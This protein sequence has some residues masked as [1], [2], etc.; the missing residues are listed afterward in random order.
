[1]YINGQKPFLFRPI[2]DNDPSVRT[3]TDATQ[4]T[5]FSF[6]TP[7]V[8]NDSIPNVQNNGVLDNIQTLNVQKAGVQDKQSQASNQEIPS[9]D[10][11]PQ[12]TASNDIYL[13]R[14]WECKYN[15]NGG[16]SLNSPNEGNTII[17]DKDGIEQGGEINGKS[18]KTTSKPDGTYS[19]EYNDGS[20]LNY[21]K[22]GHETGGIDAAGDRFTSVAKG[23]SVTR[24]YSGGLTVE[25]DFNNKGSITKETTVNGNEI[26]CT[27]YEYNDRGKVSQESVSKNNKRPQVTSY[28]YDSENRVT[29]RTKTWG[30]T[31]PETIE[32]KYLPNG[33]EIQ[34]T[35][36]GNSTITREYNTSGYLIK[37][38]SQ[39]GKNPPTI[40]TKKYDENNKVSQEIT[41]Q[42]K[43]TP[44]ITNYKYDENNNV[45]EKTTTKG[46]KVI[47]KTQY[48]YKETDNGIITIRTA[49]T[50]D[51]TVITEY[52]E[53][54]N[55]IRETTHQKGKNPITINYTYEYDSEGNLIRG[56]NSA[57]GM[58][59][60]NHI[61][62]NG[63]FDSPISQSG[64]GDCWLISGLESIMMRPGGKEYLESLV[65]FDEKTGDAEVT[66][67]GVGKTYKITYEEM[68]EAGFLANGDG[69][70]RVFELAMHKL[71]KTNPKYKSKLYQ[72][73]GMTI[74]ENWS[75]VMFDAVMPKP[76]QTQYQYE[77][78][79]NTNYFNRKDFATTAGIYTDDENNMA[80]A[81]GPQ[82]QQVTLPGNHEYAIDH[83][84]NKYVYIQNPWDEFDPNNP[85]DS[86]LKISIKDFN[87]YFEGVTSRPLN[88]P[89]EFANRPKPAREP[90]PSVTAD[91]ADNS[92]SSYV[93]EFNPEYPKI[94]HVDIEE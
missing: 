73:N 94:S 92:V 28:Q 61:E 20:T 69:D 12:P 19:R 42:G 4:G 63:K 62:G 32:Y 21:D 39:R 82:G 22:F 36:K 44:T 71:M 8:K 47:S 53:D 66:L 35:K 76:N 27:E 89:K 65:K 90:F 80:I 52:D 59:I 23:N 79:Y 67:P 77:T 7:P 31:E 14:G 75:G 2:P 51:K 11:T 84:D 10:S 57:G 93:P 54:D 72:G 88:Y 26:S 56:T 83:M 74:D 64:T 1:M 60:S 18:F 81:I 87:K 48:E 58:S 3:N 37:E 30:N 6:T 38:T 46:K 45:T 17:Y 5:N 41:K 50:D 55:E 13:S 68:E 29:K 15:N 24:Y 78:P 34:T 86:L 40:T 9:Q 16:Y 91:L 25:I 49:K 85:Q 43:D 33:N 70:I